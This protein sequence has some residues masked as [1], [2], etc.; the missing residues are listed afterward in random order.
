MLKYVD[1]TGLPTSPFKE[2]TR[3]VNIPEDWKKTSSEFAKLT[4]NPA[5]SHELK[6]FL[7]VRSVMG[8]H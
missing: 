7:K 5:F 4:Q 6:Y 3:P 2:T 8:H 1:R